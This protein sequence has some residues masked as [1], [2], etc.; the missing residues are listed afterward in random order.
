VPFYEVKAVKI[1]KY[2]CDRLN[3]QFHYSR[4]VCFRKILFKK[5]H[6]SQLFI[7]L[8]VNISGIVCHGDLI[9]REAEG[10]QVA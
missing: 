4:T 8:I 5:E 3:K 10:R 9:W 6:F 1:M 2:M 7:K